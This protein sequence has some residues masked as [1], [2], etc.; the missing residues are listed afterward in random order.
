MPQSCAFLPS[1]DDFWAK[2]WVAVLLYIPNFLRLQRHN[3]FFFGKRGTRDRFVELAGRSVVSP[4]RNLHLARLFF[5]TW[6][7]NRPDMYYGF[8][9]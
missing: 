3:V 4:C 1:F 7:F 2:F 8:L 9:Q 5:K 6:F